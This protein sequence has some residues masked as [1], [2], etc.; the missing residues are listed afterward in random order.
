MFFNMVT[1][2]A[3]H[4]SFH[5]PSYSFLSHLLRPCLSP[6]LNCVLLPLF[7]V[8]VPATMWLSSTHACV[9]NTANVSIFTQM[10]LLRQPQTKG[11]VFTSNI[12][13][14]EM[15]FSSISSRRP[16]SQNCM[17]FCTSFSL[18][19]HKRFSKP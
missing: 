18:L 3:L 1:T 4:L 14:N 11:A 13:A 8:L 12:L 10:G 17:I 7:G 19:F 5:C 2:K 15:R 16:F 9:N 6:M